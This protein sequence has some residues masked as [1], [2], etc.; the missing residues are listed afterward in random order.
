MFEIKIF[1]EK[2]RTTVARRYNSKA[3]PDVPWFDFATELTKLGHL[4]KEWGIVEYLSER[5][6]DPEDHDYYLLLEVHGEI[7]IEPPFEKRIL[8]GGKVA[9]ILHR[10]DFSC[11]EKP[12][13]RLLNWI[14]ENGYHISGNLRKIHLRCPRNTIDTEGF[15]T[16]LQIPIDKEV[17]Q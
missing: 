13:T 12:Y 4:S 17:G 8:H 6:W 16:E 2:D 11:L 14:E 7:K 3:Y 10:G 5:E 1:K 9:S 15:V